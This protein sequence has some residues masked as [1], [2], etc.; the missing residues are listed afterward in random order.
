MGARYWWIWLV[1]S[2]IVTPVVCLGWFL[3]LYGDGGLNVLSSGMFRDSFYL[4]ALSGSSVFTGIV[5]QVAFRLDPASAWERKLA[6]ALVALVFLVLGW[7]WMVVV[8]IHH[9]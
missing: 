8:G 9:F 6:A 4:K 2:S 5:L 3:M 1:C 7:V